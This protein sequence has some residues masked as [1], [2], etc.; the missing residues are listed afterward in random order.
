MQKLLLLAISLLGFWLNALS[1]ELH[2][3]GGEMGYEFVRKDVGATSYRVFLKIYRVCNDPFDFEQT[4]KI[5]VLNTTD[6][7]TST[8]SIA[9]FT[10]QFT[11]RQITELPPAFKSYCAVNDPRNC[12]EMVVFSEEVSFADSP[13]GYTLYWDMCCRNGR[14]NIDQ[15]DTSCSGFEVRDPEVFSGEGTTYSCKIPP[16]SKATFNNSPIV[17]DSSVNGCISRP[18]YYQFKYSD[19]DGDSLAFRLGNSFCMAKAATT[20]FY[21]ALYTQGYSGTKPMAGNPVISI[22]PVTGV[23]SGTPDRLGRFAVTLEVYEFRSG[24]LI[25]IH[26]KEIQINVYNCEI[27]TPTSQV[28]CENRVIDFVHQNN[29]SNS[30]NWDFG[31]TGISTDVSTDSFPRYTYPTNGDFKVRLI[32]SNPFGCT[33]TTYSLMKIYPGLIPDFKWNDP[34]CNGEQVNLQDISSFQHGTITAW[35]WQLINTRK[36]FSTDQNPVFEYAAS[37]ERIYPFTIQL[38][39]KTD[40][41]CSGIVQKVVEVFPRPIAN[42]GPDTVI[43]FHRPYTMQAEVKTD[44]QYLW[45]PSDGLSDPT[46]AR[47]TLNLNHDQTFILRVSTANTC[48]SYDTVTIRYFKGPEIYVPNAF[49]PNADGKND[50]FRIKPVSMHVQTFEIYNRW[51]HKIY[52]SPD[53]RK[54]WD[55]K[56]NGVTQDSGMYVWVLMGKDENGKSVRRSGNVMLIK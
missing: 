8:H 1:F 21:P 11:H 10:L 44:H 25:N 46:I 26:R 27:Q 18:L 23:L 38:S 30:F 2:M 28:N 48:V 15:A 34:V 55:G 40:K 53:Y 14:T 35:S 4:V 7:R 16:P 36:V 24:N 41:G 43:A 37:D 12:V 20:D 42:A 29:T 45:S 17:S 54:G 51:G 5:K 32:V 49:S 39:V 52:S 9:F 13:E 33:D 56:V 50:V 31:V 19:P 3:L 47:P 22:D 6:I